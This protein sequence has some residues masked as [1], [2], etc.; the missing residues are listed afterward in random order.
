MIE[1]PRNALVVL[2]GPAGCGK[3]TFARRHFQP[4]QIVSSDECRARISDDETDQSVSH[5]AFELMMKIIA[6]RLYLGRLCVADSTALS[7]DVRRRFREIA[8]DYRAPA[9]VIA[10]DLPLETC[11][12]RNRLRTRQVE[13][14]VLE[15]QWNRMQQVLKNLAGENWFAVHVIRSDEAPEIKLLPA[16]P[17]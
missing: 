10:W 3:S 4:T 1:I 13:E 15:R 7:N 6:L 17:K 16:A 14:G 2:C 11:K 12:A 5:L 9:L 8:A